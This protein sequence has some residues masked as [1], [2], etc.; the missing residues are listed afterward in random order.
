MN[1]TF[2]TKI[3]YGKS[4]ADEYLLIATHFQFINNT[5]ISNGKVGQFVIGALDCLSTCFHYFMGNLLPPN[6]F[7][8]EMD[9]L[10]SF[11]RSY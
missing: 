5:F 9:N 1:K 4:C 3:V 6:S 8:N 7:V 2:V 11:L 10:G